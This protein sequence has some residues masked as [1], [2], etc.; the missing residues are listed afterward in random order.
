MYGLEMNNAGGGAN[1]DSALNHVKTL[2]AKAYSELF[3][4]RIS[5]TTFLIRTG[6]ITAS[7]WIAGEPLQTI[8]STSTKT[9]QDF[10]LAL[11]IA[12]FIACLLG[13]VSAYVKRLHDFG[14]AGWWAILFVVALPVA[15]ATAGASYSSYRYEL[16]YAASLSGFNDVVSV[17]M[18]ALPILIA[19]WRGDTGDNKFGPVPRPV[20]HLLGSKFNIFAILGAAV[21]V[22][23]TS[24][25]VGL[26]QSGVWVGRGNRYE[27]PPLMESNVP[28][29]RFMQ[30]WNLRG[31]GA[32]SGKGEGSGVYRD[33]YSGNMFD[34]IVTPSGQIDIAMAG[35]RA[36]ASYLDDGFRIIPYGLETAI[37]ESG[38]IN[39]RELDK[40]MLVAIFDAGNKDSAT[41]YT[42]FAFARNKDGLPDYNVVMTSAISTSARLMA[43]PK[44]PAA[45]GR[46]MVGDC[47]AR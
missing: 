26:F 43:W 18:L 42:T 23:P 13:F 39:V 6:V 28:G 34:F 32:G 15:I 5:R 29:V 8:L 33:G 9:I 20:E 45:K 3:E 1:M 27:A 31:V 17:L 21:M 25:Y 14:L 36:S 38:Y 41:N 35:E 37:Q 2:S 7:I 24:I 47:M 12:F 16:D 4:G 19:L 40:F 11:G 46:L 10:Y 44:L 30:C 22:I